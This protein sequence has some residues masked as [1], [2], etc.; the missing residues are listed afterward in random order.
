LNIEFP[1]YSYDPLSN[2]SSTK[3]SDSKLL[4][5]IGYRKCRRI[6]G[7]VAQDWTRAQSEKYE[8]RQ[9]L[10]AASTDFLYIIFNILM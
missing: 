5:G 8:R 4:E 9:R 2:G 10:G 6:A 1:C 7:T 3:T